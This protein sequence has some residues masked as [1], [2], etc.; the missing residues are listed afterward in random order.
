MP[1][2]KGGSNWVSGSRF[3]DREVELAILQERVLDGVHILLTAQRRMGKTSLVRELFRR[4][5][6]EGEVQPVF[7][8]LEGA[9]TA[10]DAIA[11]I[12]AAS[13]SVKSA[14]RRI[15]SRLKTVSQEALERLG[16]ISVHELEV[17]LRA[18]TDHG[19][20]RTEGDLILEALAESGRPVVLAMD[21]LP[22]LVNR[23]LTGADGR[24]THSGRDAVDL[25]LGWLRRNAQHHAGHLT[26]IVLGS[27]SLQPILQRAGL[28]AKAN[29]Y[30]PFVLEPWDE[31]T[32]SQCLEDLSATYN[33]RLEESVRAAMCQRLRC[34]V[35]HHVQLFF[36]N[37]HQ[38][39][40]L[41][42]RRES[43]MDDVQHVY[44]HFMLG[45]RGQPD[46]A[47]Y[48]TRLRLVLGTDGCR[49]AMELLTEAAVEGELADEAI[50]RYR[51][52][53][54]ASTTPERT[55]VEDVLNVL[56][57]DGYLERCVT[58]H[59]FVSGL[60]EDWWR[61]R[62]GRWHVPILKRKV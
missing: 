23:L 28:S 43:T 61:S 29:I 15:G 52:A 37:L 38:H 12:A 5:E 49:M 2:K 7:V 56:E 35:P 51:P 4:L 1:L 3:F 32:A 19:N 42:G 48:E 10:E 17:K 14:W 31:P 26:M 57:H 24:M 22:L 40:V 53:L 34:Q 59:R 20:W 62:Y 9:A 8:D 54:A 30:S 27:I 13:R 25:F 11:A 60:L 33:L 36:E 55:S 6:E 21:E 45:P 41:A 47:H 44:E 58:G 46:L 39:L 18:R 50:R 16:T